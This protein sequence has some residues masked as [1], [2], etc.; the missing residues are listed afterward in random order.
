[1][2]FRFIVWLIIGF[3]IAKI[4]GVLLKTVR[5][6]LFPPSYIKGSVRD[7]K[8]NREQ[9]EIQDVDYEEIKDKK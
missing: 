8:E 4:F 9:H 5:N 6:F 2:L 7:R 3:I 1:M